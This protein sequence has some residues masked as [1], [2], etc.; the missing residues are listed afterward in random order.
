MPNP[1]VE[2]LLRMDIETAQQEMDERR[3]GRKW[4]CLIFTDHYLG[5]TV[6]LA[7]VP[8]D[9]PSGEFAYYAAI[10]SSL[11]IGLKYGAVPASHS[12]PLLMARD[13]IRELCEFPAPFHGKPM[14]KGPN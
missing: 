1:T 6:A 8:L 2:T 3:S 9:H 4:N 11:E 12:M 7:N 5:P 13:E 10:K 14:G